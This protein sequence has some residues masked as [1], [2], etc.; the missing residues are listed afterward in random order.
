MGL[1]CRISNWP[2]RTVVGCIAAL[3][4]LAGSFEHRLSPANLERAVTRELYIDAPPAAVWQSLVD[5]R[6]IRPGE[7]E[8]AWAHLIGV[9]LPTAGT[10]DLRNGEH[11]R[12]VTMGKGIHFDQVA[13]EWRENERVSWRY[14][15]DADSVPRGALDDHVRIG[16]A[17]F[18][19]G[20]TTYT[21]RPEGAGTR[22]SGRFRFRVSTHFNWYAAPVADLLIGDCA[23]KFL[24]FYS[25]RATAFQPAGSS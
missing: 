6:D 24:R 12:H 8:S 7:V 10:G 9:P 3:P 15:F 25:A 19:L 4:L 16:G 11:L 13:T 5:T 20:E 14:R 1:V 17:Y 22:L 23:E 18:D 21:L 2:R